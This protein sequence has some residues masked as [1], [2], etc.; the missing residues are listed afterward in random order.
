[1]KISEMK[2]YEI[3]HKI[4][5]DIIRQPLIA[6]P[7]SY[8]REMNPHPSM[9]KI[10]GDVDWYIIDGSRRCIRCTDPIISI[11]VEKINRDYMVE[12]FQGDDQTVSM[13]TRQEL[14]RLTE[15][16]SY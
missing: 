8:I 9:K 13:M 3:N 6:I 15:Q 11:T 10:S 7:K 12:D 1:M 2:R 14:L 4:G 16:G 5:E